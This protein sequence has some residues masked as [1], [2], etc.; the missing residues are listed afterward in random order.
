[1]TTVINNTKVNHLALTSMVKAGVVSQLGC[2][3]YYEWVKQ[4]WNFFFELRNGKLFSIMTATFPHGTELK[5]VETDKYITDAV[6]RATKF[7]A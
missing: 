6:Y 2:G 7:K 3:T 4:G 5:E 1:M